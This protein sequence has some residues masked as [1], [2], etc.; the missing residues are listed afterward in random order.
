M[1]IAIAM[2]YD[3]SDRWGIAY[4]NLGDISADNKKDYAEKW[5]YDFVVQRKK[6][7]KEREMHWAKISTLIDILPNY[8]WIFWTD[9]D[10]LV[11]NF[12]KRI[13]EHLDDEYDVIFNK[14]AN[15]LNTGHFFIKSSDWS[16]DFLKKC[17]KIYPPPKIFANGMYHTWQ[18]QGAIRTY[19]TRHP[20]SKSRT[21]LCN[22]KEFNCYLHNFEHGDFILHFAGGK[23]NDYKLAMMKK[24]LGLVIKVSN[25]DDDRKL[26]FYSSLK[27]IK[28]AIEKLMC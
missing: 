13:E 25:V 27:K 8:D 3:D 17:Y 24:Y 6:Q 12:N 22:Q 18:D 7:D 11:M 4:N 9:A 14:D 21:K 10:S 23:G 16:I 26:L 5:G 20:E 15:G 28:Q 19:L 2:A 1:K